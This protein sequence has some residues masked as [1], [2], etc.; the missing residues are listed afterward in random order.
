VR[1]PQDIFL[2]V[3]TPNREGP[4]HEFL[5]AKMELSQFDRNMWK[6][7]K[8][9]ELILALALM[10]Q[11]GI[12]H[13]RAQI[14]MKTFV[15]SIK[16]EYEIKERVQRVKLDFVLPT[17]KEVVNAALRWN[18][19]VAAEQVASLEEQINGCNRFIASTQDRL[20]KYRAYLK[21]PNLLSGI[22]LHFERV[23][24]ADCKKDL[25]DVQ[26][27]R[28]QNYRELEQIQALQKALNEKKES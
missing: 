26:K 7:G 16:D 23:L 28:K 13:W 9:D 11:Q 25:R 19:V 21:R 24:I 18:R 5:L 12:G 17:Q 10:S 27:E 2:V 14:G 20:N 8:S 3:Q 1:K 22:R 15:R 4:G 6:K